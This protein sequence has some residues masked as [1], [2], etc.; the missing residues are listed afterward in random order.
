MRSMISR[1][2]FLATGAAALATSPARSE[3]DAPLR[4]R[5]EK[6]GL[7]FGCAVQ[8]EQF[9]D[10]PYMETVSREANILVSEGELKW[11]DVHPEPDRYDFTG[12]DA[13][14]KFA[15]QNKMQ[16]RGHTLVWYASN[17]PWLEV[18]LL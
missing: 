13:I 8:K 15:A 3:D 2:N 6:H 17:P 1:R 4:V 18:E 10:I 16:M 11:P 14:A 9:Q 5:A 7:Y 12:A